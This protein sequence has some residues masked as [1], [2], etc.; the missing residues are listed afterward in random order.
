MEAKP[1][2]LADYRNCMRLYVIPRIGH[3]KLQAVRLA[4]ITRV[5]QDVLAEDGQSGRTLA[6]S[7]VIRT[8]AILLQSTPSQWSLMS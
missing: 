2:T 3:M 5:Y 1:R 4:A 8:H 6:V 7:A